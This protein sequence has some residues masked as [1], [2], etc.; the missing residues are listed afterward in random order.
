MHLYPINGAARRVGKD[1][2]AWSYREANFAQV[3]VGV[4]PDP[5]NLF[6]LE[7]NN[8]TVTA[9]ALVGLARIALRG[10]VNTRKEELNV[11]DT[12]CLQEHAQDQVLRARSL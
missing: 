4:D 11:K 7:T 6:R 10:A 5:A 9:L 8:S 1:D 3:I 12:G 2:T